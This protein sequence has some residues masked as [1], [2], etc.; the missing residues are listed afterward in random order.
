[1]QLVDNGPSMDLDVPWFRVFSASDVG[2]SPLTGAQV[3]DASEQGDVTILTYEDHP[4]GSQSQRGYVWRPAAGVP[5]PTSVVGPT[6]AF[7]AIN[8]SRDLLGGGLSPH[9]VN[10][11]TGEVTLLGDYN[12]P[13]TNAYDISEN[14]VVVGRGMGAKRKGQRLDQAVRYID[15]SWEAIAPAIIQKASS[16]ILSHRTFSH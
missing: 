8:N 9:I 15:G 14:G 7:G 11:D 4:D 1:M 2:R 5:S 16:W 13:W 6:T 10:A 12:G 3:Y